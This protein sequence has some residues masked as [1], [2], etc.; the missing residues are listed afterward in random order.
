MDREKLFSKDIEETIL[1]NMINSV[2]ACIEVINSEIK[3]DDFYFTANKKIFNVVLELFRSEDNI[4][5]VILLERLKSMNKLD[6]AGG[7]TNVTN[8]ANNSI[9]F[10]NISSYN[11]ALKSYSLKRK[12]LELSRYINLNMALDPE[13][14]HQEIASKIIE[15]TNNKNIQETTDSQN[16]SYL[17][18]LNNRM[19][20]VINTIKTGIFKI[21]SEIGGFTGGDLVTIFAFS[22]VGKTT[23]ACQIALNI[24]KQKYSVLF[25]SLEMPKE[26]IRDR[27]ISNRTGIPFKKLKNGNL[28]DDELC[29]VMDSSNYLAINNALLILEDDE[30]FDIISKIQVQVLQNEVDVIFIDYI[31][32]IN[33]TG[34]NKEEHYRVA[35]CTR[36][37]KKLAKKINKP[38]VILAQSK[39]DA[40]SKMNNKSLEIWEKVASNDL[41]GGA[42]IFRDSDIVLGMYRNTEL[43][44]KVV[45]AKLSSEGGIDYSKKNPDVNPNCATILIKKSRASSKGIVATKWYPEVFRIGNWE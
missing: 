37:L 38:I 22:G 21:D 30:L 13:Q 23:L 6:D 39:Q 19:T 12:L 17:E 31:S 34:N 18:I 14:L 44:N 10:S 3:E 27:F 11:E 45:V 26:Q 41:A 20:G 1:G 24:I 25:F 33:V 40:A 32:L 29:K 42:A 4:D 36:L 16:E 8:I 2:G 35:E 5:L 9:G 15:I 28:E 43:D 7:V